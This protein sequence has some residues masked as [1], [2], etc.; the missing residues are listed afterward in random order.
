MEAAPAIFAFLQANG[1]NIPIENITGLANSTANAKAL[2]IAEK[3]GEGYNDFYFADD[4]LQNVQAVDNILEQF[5]VKRKVQQARSKSIN[6]N[7]DF[8]EILDSTTG[9]DAD[10]QFSAAKA[11]K[12]GEDKGKWAIFIPPSAEDFVG[13]LYYFIGKGKKGEEQFKWFKDNLIS[14]LNRAY[15]ELDSAKQAISNDY[16]RLS[17][18]FPDVRKKLFKKI[19]GSEFTYNDAIRVYLWSKFGFKIW[20]LSETDRKELV[21][22]VEADE[23]LVS[24][25]ETL[26]KISKSE[27]GYV[28]PTEQWMVEDIRTDL[29]EATNKVGRKIF[30]AE[31]LE[32]AAIV[33]SEENLN[34]IEAIYGSDFREALEDML[35]RIENGTNRSFG[36]NKLVNRFMNWINGSVGT[37]MFFNSRSAVLQSLSL[38]NFINWTD[39]N[40]LAA[41]KAFANPKQFWADFT[42]IFNSD[43]LK[44]RRAGRSF[45][46]NSQELA[47]QVSNSKKPFRSALNYLLQLGFL[48][49]QIM[50]SFAIASG[51]SAFYRNRVNTYLVDGLTLVEAEQRAFAD[52]QEIAEAT[53]QSARQDMVSQQQA[54]V[55]GRIILAFQ[56]TP[57]QYARLMK[58]AILDLVAGRGDA[59]THVSRII[60]YGAVQNIMFYTLQT[61][62]FAAMFGDDEDEEVINKKTER[63]ISGSI[64]SILRGMGVGGAVVATL[65]NMVIKFAE[66]QGKPRHQKNDAAVLMEMLNISP[67]I[68]IKA[69]Q[70][71]SAQRTLNWNQDTISEMPYYNLDNPVWESAALTTQALTNIP[72]ARLHS[73]VNNLRE[74]MNKENEGWQRIALFMGWT[75]WN[76]G[77]GSKKKKKSTK[78]FKRKEFKRDTF[79]RKVFTREI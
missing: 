26:G 13:L 45:D 16:K 22:I 41:A 9:I 14:P 72:L 27:K 39:N 53:Q 11:K 51:G 44:Q 12:R 62:L 52:F 66:E 61:A 10:K 64:D 47:S 20:G 74:S 54:S 2:W 21:G 46:I 65:K 34:K 60:Y 71:Q 42:M 48:P 29:M 37:T 40:L 75:K 77:A 31:F 32:N 50:D 67:P 36:S 23:S 7:R 73:K 76:L 69:R 1:L 8:N 79:K 38:V 6:F 17:E 57:M 68:G 55:L 49:T 43:M 35:Y 25:A 30:F 78:G 59:K 18:S 56:N 15:R 19:E 28:A 5:D 58:K 63:V 4:A 70:I 3:V 24:F 33:F